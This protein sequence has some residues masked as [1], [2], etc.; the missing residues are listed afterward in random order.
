[1]IEKRHLVSFAYLWP[2]FGD[3]ISV[4]A[5]QPSPIR[6]VTSKISKM[7]PNGAPKEGSSAYP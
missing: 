7:E 3:L 2:S 5:Q 4:A 6:V 1:M